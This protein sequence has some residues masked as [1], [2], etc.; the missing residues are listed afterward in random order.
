MASKNDSIDKS[1]PFGNLK[2]I[3][4]SIIDRYQ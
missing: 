2:G 3:I 4:Y 1:K